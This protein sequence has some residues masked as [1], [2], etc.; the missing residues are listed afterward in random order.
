VV[1]VELDLYPLA[2]FFADGASLF[3]FVSM[4]PVAA[5]AAIE[6]AEL[7]NPARPSQ[8]RPAPGTATGWISTTPSDAPLPE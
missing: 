8:G 1:L 7:V 3:S 5:P 2:G 4:P 6:M